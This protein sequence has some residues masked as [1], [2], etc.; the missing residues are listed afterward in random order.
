MEALQIVKLYLKKERLNFT[1]AW[2]TTKKQLV[3]DC[4]KGDLLVDL[5]DE[6]FFKVWTTSLNLL[7]R[8][9]SSSLFV[10]FPNSPIVFSCLVP[11]MEFSCVTPTRDL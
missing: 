10:L 4:S 7:I 1:V 6:N 9:T 8:T 5:L 3:D 2:V 11:Q